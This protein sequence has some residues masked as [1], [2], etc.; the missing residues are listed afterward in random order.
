MKTKYV[1]FNNGFRST[2]NREFDF[3]CKIINLL[4]FYYEI[5]PDGFTYNLIGKE[6]EDNPDYDYGIVFNIGFK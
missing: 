1:V 6:I 3:I 5:D 4:K 2:Y